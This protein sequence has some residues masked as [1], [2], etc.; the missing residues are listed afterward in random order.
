MTQA[1]SLEI[2]LYASYISQA[3]QIGRPGVRSPMVSLEF[4]I[5][6]QLT[7]IWSWVRLIL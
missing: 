1:S 2:G 3:L 4:F 5:D 6:I 7:A